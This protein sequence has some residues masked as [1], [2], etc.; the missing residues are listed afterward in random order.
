[1]FH[2]IIFSYRQGRIERGNGA[3]RI[4]TFLRAHSWNIEVVDFCPDWTLEQLKELVKSR[5]NNDTKF[6]GFSSFINCWPEGTNDFTLWL[7]K[8]YPDVTT[9]MG[10]QG[11]LL[12][13]A[14][15]IDY[16]VDSFAEYAILELLKYTT[17]NTIFHSGLKIENYQGK[18]VIRALHDF[19]AW[20]MPS[21]RVKYELRDFL[22]YYEMLT[23]ET[24]RGCRF[25]CDFCN[26][27]V[28]GIKEDVSRTAKDLE[29]ELTFNYNEY[30]IKNYT[31][32]DETFNDRKEKI[33]KYA[34][35][36]NELDFDPW[37]MAFMRGDL[38]VKQ[39]SLWDAMLAMGLGGH[40]YGI[41]T[42]NQKA[43]KII[44]KGMNPDKL[45]QGLI[46]IKQYFEATGRYRG[47]I[48]LICGLPKET[49]ES[50]WDGIDWC[51][52]N[53]SNQSVN[54]WYLELLDENIQMPNQSAFTKNLEKYGLR[55]IKDSTKPDITRFFPSISD[56][57][58]W[59]HDDM[60]EL[61]AIE[62]M[63]VFYNEIY[64]KYFSCTGFRA[65]E[66]MV[67]FKTNNVKEVLTHRFFNDTAS[68]IDEHVSDYIRKKL[69]WKL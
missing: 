46:D 23:I 57:T 37:F 58:I 6:F 28:L 45:K 17:G 59:E 69:D 35:M 49:P 31:I 40:F 47:T 64:P 8:S 24:S 52:E 16:W 38:L 43:G 2:G 1:M 34:D 56:M 11:C 29:E 42:F 27:P 55:R 9:I 39:R 36:I 4:A 33:L 20:R 68:S 67:Q 3:H 26:F 62:I 50:F 60:N 61:Q 7:K 65:S 21:Y 12:T 48:S 41:E 66:G 25:K 14:E 53:W 19:P 44:S 32:A 10:G 63:K 15:N 54:S 22:K 51:I 13:P 30:G 5:A 18:K